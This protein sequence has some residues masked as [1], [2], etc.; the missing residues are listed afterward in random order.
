MGVV[1]SLR[2]GQTSSAIFVS[3]R[4]VTWILAFRQVLKLRLAVAKLPEK[5]LSEFICQ[6]VLVRGT[7]AMVPMLFF[8]FETVACF[9]SQNSLDNGQCK[10]ISSAAF[11]LSLYL[12]AFTL[13]SV[14]GKAV[15]Y[16]VRRSAQLTYT[17]MALLNLKWWQTIQGVLLLVT[18]VSAIYLL[19][20]LGVEG[21]E[22]PGNLV[23]RIGFLTLGTSCVIGLFT[24]SR[25]LL[26]HDERG[27][28]S[29]EQRGPAATRSGR[30]ISSGEVEGG[31]ILGA[32]L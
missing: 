12:A 23:G 30:V 8:S 14:A 21:H 6:T 17:D 16:G 27:R 4:D 15:P 25:S 29:E 19:T 24:L 26:E 2:K 13:M 11:M 1:G 32:V 9:I 28:P 3:A 5:E 31:M 20:I 10:I 22:G 18:S 7:S